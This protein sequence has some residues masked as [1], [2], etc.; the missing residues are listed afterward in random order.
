MFLYFLLVFS[1]GPRMIR[2]FV[3]VLV[4]ASLSHAITSIPI[5]GIKASAT[6]PDIGQ[7]TYRPENMVMKKHVHPFFQVWGAKYKNKPITL[8]FLVEAPRLDLITLYNGFLRDS[9]AYT[10]Y[11]LAKTIKIYQN[12]TDN[13]IKVH[14]LAKPN[15]RGHKDPLA[16]VIV[17]EKPLKNV[18][19]IIIEIED[20]YPGKLY[21]DVCVA[22]IKFWGF[23]RLPHK[24]NF[25]Q[26]TDVRDGQTYRTISVGDR[27]WMAQ[28]LRYKT[29]GSRTF[30]DANRPNVKIP[31]D[32]GLEYPTAD[33]EYNICPE[34]WR[35]PTQTEFANLLSDLSSTA[36]YD[37]LFS[38]AYRKP[39]YSIH[40]IGKLSGSQSY[41]TDAE[42]F[43]YPT[44]AYGMNFST[45]TRRY[46]DSE[47]TEETGET[48]AFG[49]YWTVDSKE[50]P[51][52]PDE[53]GN[54]EVKQLRHYRF[55]GTD[56]CEAMLCH[57]DYH[58]V[59][60][61]KDDGYTPPTYTNSESP[62]TGF[63]DSVNE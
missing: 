17:F 46:Y 57:E 25:A 4:A 2:F 10:N 53:N 12:T 48:Y 6:L 21:Q 40:Q 1:L 37:D 60:C 28:D 9:S 39:R 31:T 24:P 62:D 16:D 44:N 61:I 18:F 52:W 5:N 13:L 22:L 56:Y 51:L 41:S 15:W 47:C 11:S 33:I 27:I 23:T 54:V 7:T 32:A 59:R 3:A 55:G 58:F 36:S 20:I 42:V 26:L 63:T 34:G 19:K 30:T 45:L 8:E 50:I 38:T 29:S 14:T 43:F 49:S 35:L